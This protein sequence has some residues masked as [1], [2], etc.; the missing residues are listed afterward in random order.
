M[1]DD[2]KI[3]NYVVSNE[4][5]IE[6]QNNL[7]KLSE[8]GQA[9]QMNYNTDKCKVF[10]IGY[11]NTKTNYT[12]DGTQF[13]KADSEVDLGVTRSSNLKPS[14]QCSEVVK[15]A[16]KVNGLVGRSFEYKSKDTIL[17]FYNSL[18]RPL[19]EYCVQAWYQKDIEKLERVQCRVTK[20]IPSLRN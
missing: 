16:Y 20:I 6:I 7:N 11:Q 13:K 18:V 1:A 17:I 3:A 9:W 15:K 5:V 12:L 10:H 14:Q 4:Q 19:L 2:T 8:C